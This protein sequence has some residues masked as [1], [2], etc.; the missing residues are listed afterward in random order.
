M[1]SVGNNHSIVTFERV[2]FKTATANNGKRRAAQQYYVLLVELYAETSAGK[3]FRVATA[4]SAPLVV[5]GRSPG[6]YADHHER[7][8][9]LAVGRSISHH[10]GLSSSPPHMSGGSGSADLSSLSSPFSSYSS[11]HYGGASAIAPLGSGMAK[12]DII[13]T[14]GGNSVI[15]SPATPSHLAGQGA[16]AS[17]SNGYPFPSMM[18]D[19]PTTT[20][21]V[22]DMYNPHD[23][24]GSSNN[25]S[26]HQ[27]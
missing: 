7:Y 4:Q 25:G 3:T 6:H 22:S 26:Q 18:P 20:E 24:L 17:N 5:R 9:P 11:S 10:G 13:G 27:V 23:S 16:A 1:S 2:Q 14:S 8:N 21:T 19:I 12:M 15:M